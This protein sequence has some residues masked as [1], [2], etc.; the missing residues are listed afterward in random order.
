VKSEKSKRDNEQIGKWVMGY[1][2]K[3]RIIAILIFIRLREE[4]II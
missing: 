2:K 4:I 1:G 3:D